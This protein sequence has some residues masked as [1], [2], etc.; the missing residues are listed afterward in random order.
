MTAAALP[1]DAVEGFT[2]RVNNGGGDINS[3][4][5]ANLAEAFKR[6]ITSGGESLTADLRYMGAAIDAMQGDKQGVA[7]SIQNARIAEEFAAIPME[8]METFGEFLDEPTIEGFFN[9]VA[10]GTGQLVPSVVSTISGAGVGSIAM[11]LGKE[12]LKQSSRAAAKNIIKDSLAAVARKTA[13]PDE[14]DIAQAAF[15]ATKE[16][17]VLARNGYINS[18]SRRSAMKQG[19]LAGAGVSE[20][21]PLTGGNVSEALDSGREL[22]R[23]N[24]IRAG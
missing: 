8:G 20:F 3:L 21:A 12:A 18:Q 4:P 10:S 1:Q 19:G 9:Q 23:G 13:T 7:D 16:A 22:D 24:A 17:H 5:A 11:I 15:E 6:G 2:A 14:R